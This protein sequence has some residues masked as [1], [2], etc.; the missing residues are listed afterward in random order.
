MSHED[1]AL[2]GYL[3]GILDGEGSI[4]ISGY[5]VSNYAQGKHGKYYQI[6]V[7]IGMQNR[8]PLDLFAATFKGSFPVRQDTIYRIAYS[9]RK[10]AKML[11][12]LL[13]HLRVKRPQAELALQF[14]S[15]RK[16]RGHAYTPSERDRDAAFHA[17]MQQLNRRDA[18]AFYDQN[19][20]N[21]AKVPLRYRK[22]NAE[23]SSSGTIPED[24]I[25]RAVVEHERQQSF[26][27]LGGEENV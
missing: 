20:V 10:A 13:P 9:S 12:V 14:Q 11:K 6:I 25:V 18:Q 24:V 19:R 2:F 23:R 3:G 26:F 5:Q 4:G 27:W 15:L 1:V 7:G 8:I 17:L 21:S 22:D 16:I